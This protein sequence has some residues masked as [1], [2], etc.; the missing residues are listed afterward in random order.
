MCT[1]TVVVMVLAV[2]ITGHKW[3]HFLLEVWTNLIN[4]ESFAT[5]VW[6]RKST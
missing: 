2:I 1:D 4:I 6:Y 5:Y 3:Q